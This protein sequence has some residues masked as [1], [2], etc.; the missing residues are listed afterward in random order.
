[1]NDQSP[2]WVGARCRGMSTERFYPSTTTGVLQALEVCDGCAVRRACF[3]R[4]REE[5]WGVWG[6]IHLESPGAFGER[7]ALGEGQCPE[8]VQMFLT[9]SQAAARLEV[10]VKVLLSWVEHGHLPVQRSSGGHRRFRR[11]D[12]EELR[13]SRPRTR[14]RPAPRAASEG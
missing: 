7:G 8:R 5:R 13:A 3:E 1:M 11:E 14:A 10:S 12:V 9:S 2:W 6:G 4:G